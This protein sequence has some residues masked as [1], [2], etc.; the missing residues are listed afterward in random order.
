M[1]SSDGKESLERVIEDT[2]LNATAADLAEGP[3]PKILRPC[4]TARNEWVVQQAATI[5]PCSV[6][7][8]IG[9]GPCRYKPF[10]S[11]CDYKSQDFCEYKGNRRATNA[12]SNSWDYGR[13]DYVCDATAIPI[14]DATVD[15]VFCTEVLEHVPDPAAVI[16]E[17]ARVLKPGGKALITAP[18]TSGLHQEPFHFYGGFTPFWYQ[19]VLGEAGF[20]DIE[21]QP[22]G[23]FFRSHGQE[24]QRFST[25]IDPRVN[26]GWRRWVFAPFW[27]VTLPWLR[28]GM[29]LLCE[30]LDK[31]N[32]EP[33]FT[34]GHH[35]KAVRV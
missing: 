20:T 23:G 6:V 4:D 2:N 31:I 35:V 14:G 32:P 17:M 27:L 28:L 19:K 12:A 16:R 15:A 18:L 8:D 26:I 5:P 11:H 10:F 7:L 25:L 34:V 13:I 3:F 22:N 24:S 30:F 1:L 33:R 29:P 9:A 21:V